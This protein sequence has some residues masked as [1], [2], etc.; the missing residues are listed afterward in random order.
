M[1]VIRQLVPCLAH[2]RRTSERVRLLKVFQHMQ[3]NFHGEPLQKVNLQL[4][5]NE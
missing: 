4:R 2:S 3:R 1:F 5:P